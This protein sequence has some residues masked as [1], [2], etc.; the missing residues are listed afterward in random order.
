MEAGHDMIIPDW[1]REQLGMTWQS[2]TNLLGD[3]K[4][5]FGSSPKG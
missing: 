2:T 5:S 4:I 1:W 3:Y